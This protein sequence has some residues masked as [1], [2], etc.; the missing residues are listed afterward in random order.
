MALSDLPQEKLR[1]YWGS[2]KKPEDFDDFWTRTL[3]RP[4][5]AL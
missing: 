5:S 2:G 3:T 4:R 1:N